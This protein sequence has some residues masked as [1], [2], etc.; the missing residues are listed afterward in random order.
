MCKT[1]LTVEKKDKLKFKKLVVKY[2]TNQQKFFRALVKIAK[3]FD[4]ELKEL[5]K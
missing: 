1:T 2:D 5:L 4:P 3:D